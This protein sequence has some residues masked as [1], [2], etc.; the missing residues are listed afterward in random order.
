[1]P[2]PEVPCAG[3]VLAPHD[4]KMNFR[5]SVGLHLFVKKIL[6]TPAMRISG[7]D[8]VLVKILL[9]PVAVFLGRAHDNQTSA[10]VFPPKLL[11]NAVPA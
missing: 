5:E 4:F 8:L 6:V 11:L 1:M 3:D 9:P 2:Q 7:C 10:F